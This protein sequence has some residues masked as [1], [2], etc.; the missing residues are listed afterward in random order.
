[1]IDLGSGN[2]GSSPMARFAGSI[3]EIVFGVVTRAR[4][5]GVDID[6]IFKKFGIDPSQIL[7]L[8]KA[9]HHDDAH[10]EA[11]STGKPEEHGKAAE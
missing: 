8:T 10:E 6:G 11:G 4:A 9:S 1:M 7:G 5:M 3:P 2:N